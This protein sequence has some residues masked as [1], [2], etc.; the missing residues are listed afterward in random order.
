MHEENH[1]TIAQATSKT[2]HVLELINIEPAQFMQ[3]CHA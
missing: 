2:K 3:E 1:G